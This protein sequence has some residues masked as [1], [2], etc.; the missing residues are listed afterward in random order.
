[1]SNLTLFQVQLEHGG[2]HEEAEIWEV[3]VDHTINKCE[4]AESILI[5]ATVTGEGS[6]IQMFSFHVSRTPGQKGAIFSA[7]VLSSVKT[8]RQ[9]WYRSQVTREFSNLSVNL[10][11]SVSHTAGTS[12]WTQ[13]LL[14]ME[15]E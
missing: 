5:V 6:P 15:G 1:M 4:V 7:K 12:S 2:G 8:S 13:K 11:R 10:I 3:N 9:F 14:S